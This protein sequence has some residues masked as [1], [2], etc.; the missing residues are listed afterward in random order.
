MSEK[1]EISTEFQRALEIMD[2]GVSHLFVTGKAGS[3]KS[4]LL[5]YFC[6]NTSKN[7]A[8]LAPTGVAAVNIGGQTIHSFFGFAP[9]ITLD[10]AAKA[11]KKERGNKIYKSLET[12]IIDEVSMVR[13]DLLDCVHAFLQQA[14]KSAEA[15]GGVRLVF[16]GDLHQ[17]PPVLKRDEKVGYLMRYP[18]E[19][20]FSADI[21]RLILEREPDRFCFVELGKIYRQSDQEFIELLNVVRDGKVKS[22]HLQK[23]HTRLQADLRFEDYPHH[24]ILTTTNAGAIAINDANME[25]L[26]GKSILFRGV[27]KGEFDKK[28]LPVVDELVLKKGARVMFLNNDPAGRWINGTLGDVVGFQKT[29]DEAGEQEQMVRVKI[30]QGETVT[31]E[32]FSWSNYRV[33]FDGGQKKLQSVNVGS[34]RQMP[35]KPAWAVTIHKAQGKTFERMILDLGSGAFASGQVYVAL[36]RATS[37]EG[38]VLKSPIR[39]R[40]IIVDKKVVDFASNF[41][42]T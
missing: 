6:Q 30:D 27:V 10:E 12:L 5:K 3:G 42:N 41:N 19:H 15:F 1:I 31:V 8:L 7:Y 17:L 28:M 40:D 33:V 9:S 25:K 29:V 32:P 21:V 38:V 16:F 35:L 34:Y 13:S 36:S 39:L 11:G 18:S 2:E 24:I 4:T 14:R 20:F 37:L 22:W 26:A 23:L